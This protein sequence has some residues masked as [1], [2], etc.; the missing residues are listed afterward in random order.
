M[1]E[2]RAPATI[3]GG[4][5]IAE[6]L[7]GYGV[8]HVFFVDAILRRAM[9]ELEDLEPQQ[10]PLARA[11]SAAPGFAAERAIDGRGAAGAAG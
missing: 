5:C 9:I 3:N 1:T 6:M 11:S 10:P 2:K 4:R 7:K 8:T